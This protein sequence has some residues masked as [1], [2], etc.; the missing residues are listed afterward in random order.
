MSRSMVSRAFLAAMVATAVVSAAAAAEFDFK[1]PK[2]VNTIRFLLDSELEPIMGH[3]RGVSGSIAFDPAKPEATTGKL[4]VPADSV[5]CA[6]ERM[7]EVLHQDDWLDVAHHKEVVFTFKRVE[8]AIKTAE[9]QHTLTVRGEFLCKGVTSEHTV[10]IRLTHLPGR[11]GDR[12]RGAKGDLL[13]ARAN[14]SV[15]RFT[16]KLKPETPASVVAKEIE[17]QAAVVGLHLEE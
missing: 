15:D 11:A 4:M 6:N 2:S 17:L 1:D 8:K 13:V 3:S 7:T 5:I 16:H 10:D 12:L 14:F 9:N